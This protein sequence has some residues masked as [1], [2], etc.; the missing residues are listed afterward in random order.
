MRFNK[1]AAA[2]AAAALSSLLSASL[3]GTAS[4][5]LDECVASTEDGFDYQ[6]SVAT[7]FT[8]YWTVDEVNEEITFQAVYDGEGWVSV[9]FSDT[10]EMVV[11]D[12]VIGLPGDDT[13]LEYLLEAKNL[14]G[15][16]EA[17][18]QEIS[19][20]SVIQA[21]S[22]TTLMFTRPLSPSDTDK[23]TLSAAEGDEATFLWAYGEDNTLAYHGSRGAVTVGD[24]FCAE[25]AEEDDDEG[26]DASLAGSCES[27][28][29]DFEFE[30]SPHENL[31]LLWN[32]VDE[33]TAVSVKAI[34]QGEGW[35][36]IGF[37]DSGVMP[38][39]DSVVGLPTAET[40]LEYDMDSY[41]QPDEALLQEI[42]NGTITQADG[43]TTLTFVRLLQPE[44]NGKQLLTAT[45]EA[46]WL[47]AW[48]GSNTFVQHTVEGAF[49]LSL[50]SCD[51]R[52]AVNSGNAKQHAHGWL[53][54]IGW[55][56]C[57]PVGILFARFSESFATVGFP[58]H[59]ML[60]T[61]GFLL[62]LAGFFV[63]V[64]FTE[65]FDLDHFDNPHA[66]SGLFLTIFMMLQVVAA[67][68]RPH[69]PP[70]DPTPAH[71]R[72]GHQE[73]PKP[74]KPSTLRRAWSLSHR[75]VGYS[76]VVWSILQCY[77]GFGELTLKDGWRTLYT[78]L[79]V[80]V[81]VAFVLLQLIGLCKS[82]VM[83]HTGV[84]QLS[85]PVHAHT[86]TSH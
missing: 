40:V 65:D 78:A 82:K 49:A 60:Q 13:A 55:S 3:L 8:I 1:A 24:L 12:A 22:T 59:R 57:F 41:S 26:A 50:D 35:L 46:T 33:G 54:V 7:G 21:N 51:V 32:V 86:G 6:V 31:A 20:A 39:S 80:V 29:P 38:N 47:Y 63:A 58:V 36:S 73:A 70:K 83:Q 23:D 16:T 53:M 74:P 72:N 10:G 71:P 75:A 84:R 61:L 76:L 27:S 81:V 19:G 66:L 28:D 52:N 48:G 44:G 43:V 85:G 4:A 2:V 77:S 14:A 67:V 62:A 69:P 34:Y 45:D 79:V 37:S 18:V 42:T 64:S 56:V 25:T 17:T 11:A 30:V 9:G 5:Q 68:F 15:V